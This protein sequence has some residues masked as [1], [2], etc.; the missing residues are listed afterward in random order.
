M[1]NKCEDWIIFQII[2]TGKSLD[3]KMVLNRNIIIIQN[4]CNSR[5][6]NGRFWR[7]ETSS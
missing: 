5:N 3:L 4:V 1:P 2:F 7:N 6:E